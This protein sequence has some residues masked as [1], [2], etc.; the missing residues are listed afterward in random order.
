MR[1]TKP[2]R[3]HYEWDDREQADNAERAEEKA[4]LMVRSV[5][6]EHALSVFR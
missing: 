1:C 2:S 4:K 5:H 6:D 3:W